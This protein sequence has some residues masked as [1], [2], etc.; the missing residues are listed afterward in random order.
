MEYIYSWIPAYKQIVAK[1]PEYKNRQLELIQI[2]RDIGVNVTED[3]DTPGHRVPLTEIDPFSF[4]FYLGTPK[5][6]WNKIKVL[7]KLCEKWNI[8]IVVND[9]SGIPTANTQRLRMF[10]WKHARKNEIPRLW[11]IFDLL[12]KDGITNEVFAEF[13]KLPG[14]AKTKITE[15]FFIVQPDKYLCINGKVKP[16]LQSKGINAEFNTFTEL[17]TL[18]TNIK[19]NLKIPFQVISFESHINSEYASHIPRYYRI[20]TKAGD[21]GPSM[22]PEM[23]NNSIVSIGWEDIG[24]L[25][26][27][28]PFN[29]K[30]IHKALQD[31]GRYPNDNRT[32][33]RKA[34]EILQFKDELAPGDFVFAA[35]GTAIKA[36]GVIISDHYVFDENLGFPNCRCVKWLKTD[37]TDLNLNEGLRTSVWQYV[38]SE[39]LNQI[40]N[41]FSGNNISYS[42]QQI[43]KTN[44]MA[45]NTILFGPPGTGKTY[46][47]IE[48]ALQLLG[49]NTTGVQ[50]SELKKKFE[51]Y[52]NLSR[53]YFTTFHQNVAYEDFIEGIKPVLEDEEQVELEDDVTIPESDCKGG[54]GYS[55]ESGLFKKA[56]AQSAYLCY[57][58]F[59]KSQTTQG[60]YTF[61]DLYDSFISELKIKL[62]N[63]EDI[64][65]DTL[66]GSKIK[67]R[68]INKKNSILATAKDSKVKSSAPL[69]KE[70]FQKLYDKFKS[71]TEISTLKQ[72]EDTVEIQP[73]LT[74]FYALFKAI[75]EFEEKFKR[76]ISGNINLDNTETLTEDEIITK[77]ENGVFNDAVQNFGKTSPTVV[78]II[79][80]INRGNVSSIFGEL[81]TLI[82]SDKRWGED[83]QMKLLL[84]YSK[85]HFYV[86][87]NLYIIGT[88][89]TADRSVEALDTA[90]RRRFSFVPKLPEENKLD[91]TSDGIELSKL[92]AKVNQRLKVL[93]DND[94]TIGHAWFWNVNDL[95]GLRKVF[96]EKILPLLQ[97][98]FY[99]DYEKL[100]LVLGDNFFSMKGQVS[101]DIFASFTG[102]NG[103]AGQYDQAWQYELKN[104]NELSIA[105]FES[106]YQNNTN[107][108]SEDE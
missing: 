46:S 14:A 18:L 107:S 11:E 48:T 66:T 99:N 20:G 94:H 27:I 53:I 86:P 45:L 32:A 102:G 67:V 12:L 33:S 79:D 31:A 7:R 88:M 43:S 34:G 92:L 22:L 100:G 89:N 19:T 8:D 76:S 35:D 60:N 106:L 69:R 5:N 72:I 98:Y 51:D 61:D 82:E 74:E 40:K 2:L 80:E 83:E 84:P 30:H 26:L 105:D 64:I 104:A 78:F 42:I 29:R 96:S 97:E 23:I 47:T 6:Y 4:V 1:L 44:N 25:N 50:R 37:I 15:A 77:F 70:K 68:R 101:S 38:D 108:S 9:V 103:I 21:K 58:S 59:L 57:L 56:C 91:V 28:E 73:R 81:I 13:E 49:E 71:I 39:I 95:A 36:I 3:E 63:N 54:L 65:F 90:L 55:I 75:K 24:D 41:Y 16:Y 87:N 93:K 52:Q 17:K 85:K 10:P 62:K